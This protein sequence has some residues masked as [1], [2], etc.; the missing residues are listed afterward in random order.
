MRRALIFFVFLFCSMSVHAVP[1]V[2]DYIFDGDTFSAQ[3]SLDAGVLVTVRVRLINVDTPE[4]SGK[5]EYEKSMAVRARDVLAA[6]IPRGTVVELD[7][8][9][10][11]KYLGRIN[12][13]VFLPDGRDVGLILIDSGL[14]RP[15]KGGKRRSWCEK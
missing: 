13:N 1:A 8:V 12:A 5:C 3:V 10:D 9:K 15:Y 7:N 11:D 4:M 2:V 14:G 6:L